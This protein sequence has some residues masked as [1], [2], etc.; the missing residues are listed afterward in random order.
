MAA[1]SSGTET[2]TPAQK[3]DIFAA[4]MPAS[5]NC[6]S[7]MKFGVLIGLI[8]VGEISNRDVVDTVLN[9]VSE[10]RHVI[11]AFHDVVGRTHPSAATGCKSWNYIVVFWDFYFSNH[12]KQRYELTCFYFVFRN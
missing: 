8:E 2:K 6:S 9:L 1:E 10:K 3:T 7:K 4:N 12:Y 11:Y 5:A